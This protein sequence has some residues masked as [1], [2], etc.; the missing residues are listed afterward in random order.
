MELGS[1]R[2]CDFFVTRDGERVSAADTFAWSIQVGDD[3]AI[4]TNHYHFDSW[5][6]RDIERLSG[7]PSGDWGYDICDQETGQLLLA[8][9][10]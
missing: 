1:G 8:Y 5:L 2:K 9:R 7:S 6:K 3:G 4:D 10:R